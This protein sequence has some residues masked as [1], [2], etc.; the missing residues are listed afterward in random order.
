MSLLD[1][2]IIPQ[3]SN[4]PKLFDTWLR[5]MPDELIHGNE[6][7]DTW[8][9]FDVIGHLI[10]GEKTDWIPRAKIIIAG[11]NTPFEPFD[12]FA[13]FESSQGKTMH[14]LLD[15]FS[16][17]RTDNIKELKNLNITDSMLGLNG[18]HP[19]LG[20]VTLENLLTTW[21]A[22]DLS[23]IHQVSRVLAFQLKS[24]VGPWKQYLGVIK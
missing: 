19:A 1:E 7:K 6:G 14:Q 13:Q 18:M 11:T 24:Q 4:T 21:V 3:L 15:E 2:K 9:P 22:H 8:S 16:V 23:H 17:L 12:R 10:H 20:E 5:N